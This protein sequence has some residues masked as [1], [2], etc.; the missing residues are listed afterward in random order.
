M[1]YDIRSRRLGWAGNIIRTE[2][3]RIPKKILNGNFIT[4]YQWETHEQDG[5]MSSAEDR[6]E[7][8]RLLRETRAQKGLQHHGWMDG[9]MDGWLGGWVGGWMDG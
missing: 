1:I 6:E 8:R 7:W 9:W 3:E 4:Q 2:N 5:W